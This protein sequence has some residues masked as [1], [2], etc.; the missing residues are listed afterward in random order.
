VKLVK[1]AEKDFIDF[2]DKAREK[3]IEEV[4]PKQDSFIYEKNIGKIRLYYEAWRF[5]YYKGREFEAISLS[6]KEERNLEKRIV[7]W[8]ADK[9]FEVK[10]IEGI[11]KKK[12]IGI[13][14][15]KISGG[16]GK[17]LEKYAKMREKIEKEREKIKKNYERLIKEMYGFLKRS[18]LEKKRKKLEDW[19][20]HLILEGNIEKF[21]RTDVIYYSIFIPS[22]LDTFNL[23]F[24]IQEGSGG[25]VEN[26]DLK[27][28][29]NKN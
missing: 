28:N 1:I 9:F 4:F 25:L 12:E 15:T 20:H 7:I 19:K 5:G 24:F 8:G 13:Y 16:F 29:L 26:K 17:N 2:Y 18:F 14:S 27:V 22:S 10:D 21:K 3:Y 6:P 11:I 23:D